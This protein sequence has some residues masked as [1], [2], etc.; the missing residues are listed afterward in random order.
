MP[1]MLIF[2]LNFLARL[3]IFTCV[4]NAKVGSWQLLRRHISV[5]ALEVLTV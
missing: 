1:C 3:D 2:D 4:L 5:I